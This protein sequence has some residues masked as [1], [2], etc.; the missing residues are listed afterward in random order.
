MAV[1]AHHHHHQQPT[2]QLTMTRIKQYNID[3]LGSTHSLTHSLSVLLLK[4]RGFFPFSVNN[5]IPS[6]ILFL[7][8]FHPPASLWVSTAT[9]FSNVIFFSF[10]FRVSVSVHKHLDRIG[11][12]RHTRTEVHFGLNTHS[13][14]NNILRVFSSLSRCLSMENPVAHYPDT[15]VA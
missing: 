7:F 11:K 1:A 5:S 13:M 4:K 12:K 10:C 8:H 14:W 3:V 15:L 9:T 6:I 2:Q